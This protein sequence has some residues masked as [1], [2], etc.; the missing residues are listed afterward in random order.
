MTKLPEP[1]LSFD[2]NVSTDSDLL[3]IQNTYTV[4]RTICLLL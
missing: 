1:E 2:V 4:L 3:Y